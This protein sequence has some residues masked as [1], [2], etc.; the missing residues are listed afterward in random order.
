MFRSW[1]PSAFVTVCWLSATA[2][3]FAQELPDAGS[4]P[5]IEPQTP[6]APQAQ[7][8]CPERYLVLTT[9]PDIEAELAR[10]I[11]V[12][13]EVELQRRG[14][15]VCTE[16]GPETAPLAL[17]ALEVKNGV[18]SIELDD[19]ATQKRVAR[20]LRLS[21]VPETGRALAAAIAIDELLRASWAELTMEH[22]R[23]IGYRTS[24][25]VAEPAPTLPPEPG[26]RA[27]AAR[28]SYAIAASTAYTNGAQNFHAFS[29]GLRASLFPHRLVWVEAGLAGLKS[30]SA[31]G[32]LGR[33]DARGLASDLTLGACVLNTPKLFLC[34]GARLGLDWLSFHAKPDA[35]LASAH[36]QR[37]L[38]VALSGV[39]S[40]GIALPHRLLIFVQ[41]AWG[42]G[43]HSAVATEGD[44]AL[45]GTHGFLWTGILGLGVSQ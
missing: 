20:D 45:L 30:L 3:G 4:E 26:V 8:R 6:D 40:L 14:M 32:E 42:A 24:G 44:K 7:H 41:S 38:A 1:L 10:E 37:S 17:V 9:G 27:P 36:P 5:A 18:L 23:D 22:A 43:V 16:T 15:G 34:A 28:R 21:T 11:R 2:H 13:L 12:D 31:Q 29:T 19:R 33:V 35:A 25:A 39:G